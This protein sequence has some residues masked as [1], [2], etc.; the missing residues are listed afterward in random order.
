MDTSELNQHYSHQFN[1]E[2]EDIR[3]RVLTMGGLVEQQ[4]SIAIK[5]RNQGQS[6]PAE[7]VVSNDYQ[8]NAY[9]VEIDERCTA[10]LA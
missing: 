9:D 2:L 3:S 1:T 8:V 6:H 4:L 7:D 5:A 10:I